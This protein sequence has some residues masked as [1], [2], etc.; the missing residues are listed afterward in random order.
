MNTTHVV[1]N[2]FFFALLVGV[3][4]LVWLLFSPFIAAL[5]L[6]AIIVT[7]CY[8]VND[9]IRSRVW[10]QS[11]S[12]AAGLTTL[13]VVIVIILP[14]L[15]LTSILVGETVAVYQILGSEQ[16]ALVTTLN[17]QSERLEQ[18]FPGLDLNVTEYLRQS[19]EWLASK[20]G[21]IFV[22]TAATL[23]SFFIAMIGSF[24]FFRDGREF[25]KLLIRISPLPDDRDELILRRTATAVRS[26]ATGSVLIAI[27]Q[28]TLTAVGLT[29]V[30]FDR[31]VLLGVL[32]AFGALI[33]G[34]GTTIVIA[35]AVIYLAVTGSFAAAI[36]LA[37]WGTLAVGLIDNLLGPYL[38]SRGSA[39][40]P[41]LILLS[42]LG[43]VGLFGP[44]GFVVGPVIVSLFIVLL[45]LYSKHII[46]EDSAA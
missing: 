23:F 3:G 44:I 41:F 38:M 37:L 22:G 43:G 20:L 33:P 24:Y 39:L 42:V 11:P 4:F 32:A 2:V 28:G 40:H 10:R 1:Q 17:E 35:P 15:W 12:L 13:L 14:V 8:P 26:V 16:E 46:H 30:G 36:F 29:L 34:V 25:T 31:A 18:Y 27:I 7:I 5:A 19:A 21:A 9:W 6:S 45:E